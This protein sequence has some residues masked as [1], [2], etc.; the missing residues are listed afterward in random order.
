MGNRAKGFQRVINP[1][2]ARRRLQKARGREARMMKRRWEE[3][4]DR[5]SKVKD[6]AGK[7]DGVNDSWLQGIKLTCL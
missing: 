7:E 4:R 3:E 1:W 5:R 2:D 6:K